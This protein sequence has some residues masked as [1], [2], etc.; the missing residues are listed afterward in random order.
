MKTSDRN[1]LGTNAKKEDKDTLNEPYAR[2]RSR[3]SRSR[4]LNRLIPF[5]MVLIF[6]MLILKDQ[7][8]AIG[9]KID[10]MINPQGFAAVLT[11][12][13]AALSQSTTPDFARL[14]K[15]GKANTTGKGFFVN[16][17]VVGEMDEQ[18]GERLMNISCHIDQNGE[19]IKLNRLPYKENS[20]TTEDYNEQLTTDVE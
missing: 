2:P 3:S 11:C 15:S 14:I 4:A 5:L 12:R 13:N 20:I 8:P 10:S 6:G 7:V 9:D 1:P 16:Q 19:I 18:S 17:L